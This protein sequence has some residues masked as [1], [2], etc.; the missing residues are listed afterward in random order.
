MYVTYFME[1][2]SILM[3]AYDNN[4]SDAGF[5]EI[6]RAGMILEPFSIRIK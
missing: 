5:R 2:K 1:T 4:C 6:S 3:W